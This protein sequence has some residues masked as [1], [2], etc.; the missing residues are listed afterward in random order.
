[1]SRSLYVLG[2]AALVFSSKAVAAKTYQ[3]SES[4]NSTD[5]FDHFNFF[6]SKYGTGNYNDV[7]PTSGFVNYRNAADAKDLGLIAT[8]GSE[9]YIGVDHANVLSDGKGRNSVRLE[10]KSRYGGGLIVASFSHLPKPVCGSW[11][12]YWMV[13]DSWPADGE[14]DIYENWNLPAHN[15]ITAHS[16]SQSKVGSCRLTQSGF[17]GTIATSNCDNNFHDDITQ[18]QNQGCGV[19]ET[20]GQWGS[21][22][23]GV[24]KLSLP[25]SH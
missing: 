23:G 17:S 12:A 1:M 22:S 4:F 2:A 14:I 11:P 20:N 7:D 8:Q 21:A 15:L 19:T 18:W 10:S 5:F 24:C 9:V 6:E 25:P 16:D 3:I 13:G